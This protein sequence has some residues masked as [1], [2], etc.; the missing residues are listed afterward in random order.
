[1][2]LYKVK[3][4]PKTKDFDK[5]LLIFLLK[6][7]PTLNRE[8]SIDNILNSNSPPLKLNDL[9][10]NSK[11][12]SINEVFGSTFQSYWRNNEDVYAISHTVKL[13]LKDQ[14]QYY[15][16]IEPS[17]YGEI[18]DF[19]KGILRPIYYK[20]EKDEEYQIVTFDIDFNIT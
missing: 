15:G 16:F 1:M 14:E 12:I 8:F 5:E 2:E 6:N 13:I 9:F 20:K 3:I 7:S 17:P 4:F 10:R 19:N 11:P 18:I